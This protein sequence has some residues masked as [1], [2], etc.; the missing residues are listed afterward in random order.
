MRS[1]LISLF[2]LLVLFG[3]Y[4]TAFAQ[5]NSDFGRSHRPDLSFLGGGGGGSGSTSVP[6]PETLLLFGSG[7][8]GFVAWRSRN[9]RG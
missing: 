3:G 1:L 5:G 6:L 9:K 2:G 8:A 4:G 7:V